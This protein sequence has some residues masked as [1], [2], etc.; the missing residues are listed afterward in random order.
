MNPLLAKFIGSFV[1]WALT[2]IGAWLIAKGIVTGEDQWLEYVGAVLAWVLPLGWGLLEKVM[3]RVTLFKA[4][5]S[6]PGT[7]EASLIVP[8]NPV[9]QLAKKFVFVLMITGAGFSAT[10]CNGGA[11]MNVARYS[12]EASQIGL[13]AQELVIEADKSGLQPNKDLTAKAMAAFRNL[14]T[15]LQTLAVALRTYD[16]AT[17]DEAKSAQATTIMDIL[18]E[19]RRLTRVVMMFVGN[20][21]LGQQLTLAFDNLDRIFDAIT[22][23]L[24][25]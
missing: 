1:R 25:D 23:A 22:K 13:R 21:T 19:A 8:G 11:V 24:V 4:L 12:A 7:P 17:T 20:D 18:Q 15:Q 10:A 9:S 5:D 6:P 16:N 3:A 2:G 14:G